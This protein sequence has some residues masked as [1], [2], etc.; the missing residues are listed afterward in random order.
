VTVKGEKKLREGTSHAQS[1][2]PGDLQEGKSAKP[3]GGGAR[4]AKKK[5]VRERAVVPGRTLVDAVQ[6]A[7]E[8]GLRLL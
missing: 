1:K 2:G 8:T 3:L 6:K 5:Q 7:D 4:A